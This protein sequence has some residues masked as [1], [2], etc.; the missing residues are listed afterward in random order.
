MNHHCTPDEAVAMATD[1][2]AH[3]GYVEIFTA[4]SLGAKQIEPDETI[5]HALLENGLVD[6]ICTD[7]S[8]G[9]HDSMPQYFKRVVELGVVTLPEIVHLATSSPATKIPG[10][11][12]NKGLI[13]PGKI[14]DLIIVE[15]ND[16]SRVR[17]VII[18]G[19]V[20]VEDGRIIRN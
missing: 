17:Y 1:V 8:G 4:D 10:L 15:K 3:G 9:Y 18:A 14:A 11:A 6:A 16:I 13:E 20:V 2:R 19:R 5:G 7:Y 12:P